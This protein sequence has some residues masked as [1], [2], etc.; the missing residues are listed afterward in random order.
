[1]KCC[2]KEVYNGEI[3]FPVPRSDDEPTD[4]LFATK[5]YF[6]WCFRTSLIF[7]LEGHICCDDV[8][9]G[10]GYLTN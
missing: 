9:V 8:A 10:N 5:E 3:R 2:L 6:L 4:S 1:M 7:H